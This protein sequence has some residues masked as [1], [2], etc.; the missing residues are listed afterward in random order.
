[1]SPRITASLA[2]SALLPIMLTACETSG[3][4]DALA[5][6]AN[7]I[8]PAVPPEQFQYVSASQTQYNP[9]TVD[10][11][12]PTASGGGPAKSFVRVSS[13]G[14]SIGS[15][16][17]EAVARAVVVE[18]AS[19]RLCQPGTVPQFQ[20]QYGHDV[21][22]NER[23]QKW[24]AIVYC[25]T[26]PAFPPAYGGAMAGGG[27]MASASGSGQMQGGYGGGSQNLAPLPPASTGPVRDTMM[28]ISNT[29]G[30]LPLSMMSADNYQ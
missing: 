18:A 7:T 3:S 23:V 19:E 21:Y 28:P 13:P 2:L 1:M 12:R 25:D 17:H 4:G 29:N 11:T 15:P 20:K 24:G 9:F 30:P 10:M 8:Q 5:E 14:I 26:A 22:L 16:K 27:A 6:A